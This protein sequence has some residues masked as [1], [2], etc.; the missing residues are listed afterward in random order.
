MPILSS[1]GATMRVIRSFLAVVLV[2]TTLSASAEDTQPLGQFLRA[3][4]Q[5]FETQC[6]VATQIVEDGGS[7]YALESA[8]ATAASA[9]TCL[10][11]ELEKA[12]EPHGGMDSTTPT[13]RE[14]ALALVGG[15]VDLCAARELRKSIAV[16]CPLDERATAGVADRAAFCDCVTAELAATSDQ[17][18]AEAA[19]QAKRDFE[20]KVEA[21]TRGEPAPAAE[22][23]L[24]DGIQATCRARQAPDPA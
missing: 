15:V 4:E 16:Q 10:P 18:I 22:P 3:V 1:P 5:L 21:R 23:S 2:G 13:A 6:Q 9:C 12:A 24:I 8:K 20:A 7:G 11:V 14:P 19:L 17:Q